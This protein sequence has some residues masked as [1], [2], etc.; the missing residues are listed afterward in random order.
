[1][2]VYSLGGGRPFYFGCVNIVGHHL[3]DHKLNH[4]SG[5]ECPFKPEE[6]DIPFCP[7][8]NTLQGIAKISYAKGWTILSYWDNSIDSRPGS[9]STF[10]AS[11]EYHFNPMWEHMYAVFPSIFNRLKLKITELICLGF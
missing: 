9:H 10:L 7:P 1:M 3:W 11:G 4:Y 6:L 8:E 5:T 2:P